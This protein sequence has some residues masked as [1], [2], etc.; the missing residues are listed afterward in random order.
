[1]KIIDE[2]KQFAMRGSVIDLAIG[3]I[4][5]GAFGKIVSSFVNDILMPPLGIILGGVNFNDLKLVLGKGREDIP[6]TLNYGTFIQ[7]SIDFL[8]IALAIFLMI[9]AIN[10]MKKKEEAKSPSAA[11]IPNQEKLLMEIRDILKKQN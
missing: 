10:A 11:S 6:V 1:M 7:T 2:F 3:I 5:G 8:I 4:I 9:K